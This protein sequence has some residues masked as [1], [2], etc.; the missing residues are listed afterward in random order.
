MRRWHKVFK[1]V[2]QMTVAELISELC[3]YDLDQVVTVQIGELDRLYQGWELT[4]ARDTCR[5]CDEAYVVIGTP[6]KR[7]V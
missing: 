1:E 2:K 5:C 3:L 7:V 6:G 4:T